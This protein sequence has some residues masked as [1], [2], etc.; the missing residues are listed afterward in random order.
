M[1][2][3]TAGMAPRERAQLMQLT[4]AIARESRIGV[5][6]TEHDMDAVFAHADDILVLVRGE[7]IARGRPEEVRANARVRE[8]YLGGSAPAGGCAM[9]EAI[10]EVER[11]DASYGQAQ[12][13][14]EV[15]LKLRRG[16]IV[17]LMGRN[18]A[19]KSTTLK[20]IMGL[21]PPRARDAALCRP[22]YPGAADLSHRPARPRLRAGGPAHLH[23]PHRL[24]E[25]GGRRQGGG[26]RGRARRGRPSGCSRSSPT[27]PR[28]AA[29]APARC[30]AASS[31]C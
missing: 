2:E 8:V 29:G 14:F 28:C 9:S 12:I 26:R 31:R 21:V 5:L 25:P 19:G 11:L 24:R 18:G 3:P 13:L 4:A 20:A 6:F 1:D 16:E 15:S 10:L 7:I 27:S 22:R 30:R 23:R 17:A